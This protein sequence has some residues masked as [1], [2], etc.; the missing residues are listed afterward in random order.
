M[1]QAYRYSLRP[2][3]PK[4]YSNQLSQ[5]YLPINICTSKNRNQIPRCKQPLGSLLTGI[6]NLSNLKIKILQ[7][8]NY[9]YNTDMAGVRSFF[10]CCIPHRNTRDFAEQFSRFI[11]VSCKTYLHNKPSSCSACRLAGRMAIHT[12]K[13]ENFHNKNRCRKRHKELCRFL[14]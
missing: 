7:Y 4:A 5:T 13:V 3:G 11:N 9:C 12:V 8:G 6:N 2:A 14:L 10:V 1:W